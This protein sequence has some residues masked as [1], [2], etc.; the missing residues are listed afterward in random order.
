ME[1]ISLEDIES[2]YLRLKRAIYYEN[3]VL[4]HLKIKLAEFENN[5]EFLKQDKRKK[6]F[7]NF[8]KEI[9]IL[10][11]GEDSKYFNNLFL[12][13][14]SKKVIK[15][16][17]EKVDK[18]IYKIIEENLKDLEDAKKKEKLFSK[19]NKKI[20][21]DFNKKKISYNYFID[22][23]IE[24]HI[25]SVLWIM[26]VGYKLDLQLDR[27][28]NI[29]S[30]GYRLD[31]DK[32]N[33]DSFTTESNIIKEKT[34][35][36]RYPEQYQKWKNNGIKEVKHI[37]E[38]NENA[39]II[40]LDLK[41]FYYNINTRE[42]ENKI[43]KIDENILN[44]YLT[45]A[46]L[47]I[48]EIYIEE[49]IRESKADKDFINIRKKKNIIPIGIYSSAILA[50]IYLKD[51][52]NMILEKTSPNYYGRYVDDLF[53]VFIEYDIEKIKNKKKYIK[54]KLENILKPKILKEIGVFNED[55]LLTN[56]KQKLFLLE[57]DKG[58]RELLEIEE[59]ILE[60]TSTFAF[61]PK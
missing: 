4:L 59:T 45:Q 16:L 30:Y 40:N 37:L 8:K 23:P 35:F 60:R 9:D 7:E 55:I 11:L 21:S 54:E 27:E 51:L 10:S 29:Y 50:N 39:V 19:I 41:K 56:T 3:N 13:I 28:K 53:L 22:C 15:K 36:K 34:I 32:N 6:F 5:E 12:K 18:N 57:K 48:N 1:S 14:K 38:K 25:L 33:E 46:I 20:Q 24:L 26:K 43:K 61:L 31:M 44:S 2:A 58:K 17:N 49:F 42:L 47:T 52:D